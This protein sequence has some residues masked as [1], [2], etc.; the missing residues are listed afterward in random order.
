MTLI[1]TLLAQFATGG[2]LFYGVQKFFKETQEKLTADAKQQIA[3]WLLGVEVGRRI[4][5]P[6]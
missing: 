6:E 5:T 2:G 4:D 1:P 3:S